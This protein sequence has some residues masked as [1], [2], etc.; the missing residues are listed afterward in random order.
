MN[1]K[2]LASVLFLSSIAQA[3]VVSEC[4]TLGGKKLSITT[5]DAG[6]VTAVAVEGKAT[7]PRNVYNGGRG[8]EGNSFTIGDTQFVKYMYRWTQ[9][10][11]SGRN[12]SLSCSD[13][14]TD[15]GESEF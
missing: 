4:E 1:K 5:D 2:L 14:R 10:D 12:R 3:G 11:S 15:S 8:G 7:T 13:K 9:V 6:R